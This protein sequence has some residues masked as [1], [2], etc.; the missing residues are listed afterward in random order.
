ME[1]N[2]IV[3]KV[4][5][6]YSWVVADK[7]RELAERLVA[8]GIDVVIDIWDLKSGQ[9][10]YAF[11]EQCVNDTSI[12]RVLIICDESYMIKA[13]DRKGGVG[14]ETVIITPE[15]YG[16]VEQEKFIPVLFEK[17]GEGKG[18]IPHFIKSRIYIDLSG[19]DE[20]YEREF[21]ALLRN[22]H[23]K[24]LHAKPALGRCPDW[25]NIESVDFSA[26]RD[27]T[28]QIRSATEGS[29]KAIFLVK[30]AQDEIIRAARSYNLSEVKSYDDALLDVIDQL[31]LL[32]DV[33][34]D[35]IDALIYSGFNLSKIVVQLMQDLYNSLNDTS[36][37]QGS[38]SYIKEAYSFFMWE[39][40][41][42]IIATFL[43]YERYAEIYD[44][45]TSTFFL[46]KDQNDR[47]TVYEYD[48]FRGKCSTLEKV[49]KPKSSTPNLFT[50][51][52]QL[53]IQ[54]ERK[55]IIT[56]QS[57]TNADLLLYQLYPILAKT[58]KKYLLWFPVSY[59]YHED[60]Q[61]LW[62]KLVSRKFC[63]TVFPLFGVKT[64]VELKIAIEK[65]NE[66]CNRTGYQNS[67][68]SPLRICDSIALENVGTKN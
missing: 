31:K 29:S 14:D 2:K 1:E 43:Y 18:F 30:K 12:F 57:L 5:I 6:S 55:P 39:L 4:F 62:L 10:K 27:I 17:D 50:L 47:L 3:P 11:M 45:L 23:K 36:T 56:V 53:L 51:Q 21:E 49:C 32:R 16:H 19:N 8:N 25:L 35:Y 59:I 22:I 24:P 58:E 44:V 61:E 54:R 33:I 67:Y 41:I 9:D 46:K 63:E 20:I 66:L 38:Q 64:L 42:C 48:Q 15:I 26:I 40:F 52:G 28:R 37:R 34:L 60:A 13:N 7:V 65:S 68:D